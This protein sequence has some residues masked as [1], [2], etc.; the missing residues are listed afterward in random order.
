[1][2]AVGHMASLVRDFGT[3]LFLSSE[4]SYRATVLGVHHG[5]GAIA[6]L[7][8][9]AIASNDQELADFCAEVLLERRSLVLAAEEELAWFAEH[10]GVAQSRA[11]TLLRSEEA[12]ATPANLRTAQ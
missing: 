1:M 9:V 6:L 2:T 10:P 4:K 5:I 8:D 7:E 11:R 12:T 3:D